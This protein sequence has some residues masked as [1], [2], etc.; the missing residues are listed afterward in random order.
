[1]KRRTILKHLSSTAALGVVGVG[2]TGAN[3]GS[4]A[5]ATK[6]IPD[7]TIVSSA[8]REKYISQAFDKYHSSE[9]YS[10]I[11]SRLSNQNYTVSTDDGLVTKRG[12]TGEYSVLLPIQENGSSLNGIS[13]SQATSNSNTND[14]PTL[15]NFVWRSNSPDTGFVI[16]TGLVKNIVSSSLLSEVPNNA[17]NNTAIE[18]VKDDRH[19]V[20]FFAESATAS[21]GSTASAGVTQN[22][23]ITAY[24]IDVDDQT[25]TNDSSGAT[26]GS[27]PSIQADDCPAS[28]SAILGY[29]TGCAGFTAACGSVIGGN[30]AGLVGCLGA[31]ACGCGIGC[32]LGQAGYTGVCAYADTVIAV[33]TGFGQA[34]FSETEVAM[35]YCIRD[36]CNGLGC[37]PL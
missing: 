36:G 20:G 13:N 34:G 30:L 28:I 4:G 15:A 3:P 33:G 22:P 26:T 10:D 8:S 21:T 27:E 6:D 11:R 32:C 9:S 12:D 37:N 5:A 1:M 19:E 29:I 2:T 16:R 7:T 25:V 18:V 24:S 17:K 23:D 35:A 14:P 31:V